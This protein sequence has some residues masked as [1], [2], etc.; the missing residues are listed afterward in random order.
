MS[1][2][3]E[4]TAYKIDQKLQAEAEKV[5]AGLPPECEEEAKA[6]RQ[7][8]VAWISGI[9]GH[10]DDSGSLVSDTAA[11]ELGADPAKMRAYFQKLWPKA[12]IVSR[13]AFE[14]D[15]PW[16]HTQFYHDLRHKY[17]AVKMHDQIPQPA[18]YDDGERM[19]M[20]HH[21]KLLW[22]RQWGIAYVAPLAG[23][24]D[25][26]RHNADQFV[27]ESP[28]TAQDVA[29]LDH[30][31]KEL[32][33][34][35]GSY[36]K[37]TDAPDAEFR[38]R[39]TLKLARVWSK[40][41]DAKMREVHKLNPA[42]GDNFENADIKVAARA[43][44]EYMALRK[45]EHLAAQQVASLSLQL[46]SLSD[47]D[48]HKL[49]FEVFSLYRELSLP[50]VDVDA[51][52]RSLARISRVCDTQ[53]VMQGLTPTEGILPDVAAAI[54]VHNFFALRL[55]LGSALPV[56]TDRQPEPGADPGKPG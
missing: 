44:L 28:L 6:I 7:R 51:L 40:I 19:V 2:N 1:N 38:L 47:D 20:M 56:G 49:A 16:T 21:T 5:L 39:E 53:H 35:Y 22:G 25:L 24:F 23:P 18:A 50:L 48:R 30:A 10:I 43:A 8:L 41:L 52:R 11:A 9:T 12:Y 27:S 31:M 46:P 37:A 3:T 33:E 45:D 34:E 17:L 54:A 55:S 26:V 29:S 14:R 15:A 42:V 32:G 36:L 4:P 13:N